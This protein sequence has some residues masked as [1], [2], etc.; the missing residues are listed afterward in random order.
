MQKTH[1]NIYLMKT[2]KKCNFSLQYSIEEICPRVEGGV[3]Q[4]Q[5]FLMTRQEGAY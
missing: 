4:F 2:M 1:Y 5:I 3:G